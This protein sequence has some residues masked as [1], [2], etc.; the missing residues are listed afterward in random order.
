MKRILTFVLAVF[1]LGCSGS[2]SPELEELG[3][4]SSELAAG[5]VTAS[6]STVRI[7]LDRTNTGTTNVCWSTTGVSTAEVWLS[8]NGQSEVLFTRAPSGCADATWITAGNVFE[9]RLYAEMT[10]TTL[11]GFAT[12]VGEGYRGGTQPPGCPSSCIPNYHCCVG[13]RFCKP[14][15]QACN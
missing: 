5:Y 7:N 14:N 10:H 9:F 2:E 15:T 11:L 12:V 3:Q 13:E 8:L 4:Q 6:P 1:V